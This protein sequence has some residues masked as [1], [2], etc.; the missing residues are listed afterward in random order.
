MPLEDDLRDWARRVVDSAGPF[1]LDELIATAPSET[2]ELQGSIA[3]GSSGEDDAPSFLVVA[4]A[5]YAQF[6]AAKTGWWYA[7]V[8]EEAWDE[9][10][11]L[12]AKEA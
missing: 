6:V 5:D 12:A 10:L 1:V 8:N 9:F 2:G 7:T 11:G 3:G 4:T